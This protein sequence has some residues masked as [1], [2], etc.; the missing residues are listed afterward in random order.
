MRSD[1]ETF[2][3]RTGAGSGVL[4]KAEA[5]AARANGLLFAP[6]LAA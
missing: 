5:I 1:L 6:R 3:R 2:M 4:F